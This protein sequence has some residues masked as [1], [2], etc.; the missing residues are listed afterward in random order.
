[1]A[2]DPGESSGVIPRDT[3]EKRRL[4]KRYQLI[5]KP[6][7]MSRNSF[8]Y[9]I[10]EN[11]RYGTVGPGLSSDLRNRNLSVQDLID[12]GIT[13]ELI[14]PINTN[15]VLGQEY[16]PSIKNKVVTYE[17]VGG[18]SITTF[19]EAIRSI[20]MR[21]RIIRLSNEWE[22][23]YK[24]LE[25][26][27]YLSGNQSRYYGSVYLNGYDFFDESNEF[28]LSNRYKITIYSLDFNFK[29]DSNTTVSADLKMYVNQDLSRV[30]NRWGQL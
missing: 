22:L 4:L 24:S 3:E 10:G 6:S 27:S 28:S 20:G 2:I 23:Y 21:L 29:S 11:L 17:T 13:N 15:I 19:G 7:F 5:W 18:N 26:L 9:V 14:L 30:R 16:S 8:S 1:M 25:A 12:L